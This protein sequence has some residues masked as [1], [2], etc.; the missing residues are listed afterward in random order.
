MRFRVFK[1]DIYI[2]FLFV[3]FFALLLLFDRTGLL[4]PAFFAAAVHEG[5]HIFAM[6]A[7]KNKPSEIRISLGS[8]EIVRSVCFS[9]GGQAFIQAAGPLF[10]I[11]FFAVFFVFY[12]L[13]NSEM[14]L[15]FSF[16]SLIY[17]IFNLIPAKG[18]DGGDLLYIFLSRK[19]SLSFSAAAVDILTGIFAAGSL[20][21]LVLSVLSHKTDY[22]FLLLLIYF[23]IGILSKNQNA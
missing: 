6:S 22:R 12:K 3:A 2:S 14:L 13:L 23:L 19:H 8:V 16:C 1:T 10:N 11:V 15:N 17:G 9:Y 7:L 18:L 4:M 21:M 5:G 20:F